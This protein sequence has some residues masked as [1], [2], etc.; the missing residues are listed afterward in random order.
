MFLKTEHIVSDKNIKVK[1][2]ISRKDELF[3]F[4]GEKLV[5]DLIRKDFTPALLLVNS[6]HEKKFEP[7]IQE[8][9]PVWNVSEK[10][11]R[12]ISSLKSPPTIIAVYEELPDNP[13]IYKNKIIFAMDSIQ[14]PGNLGSIFRCAAAFGIRSIALTGECVK[15]TNNKLLRAAQN[16]VFYLSVAKYTSLGDFIT[17][18]VE[19]KFNIYLTSSRHH[20]AQASIDDIELPAVLVL[21]NEGKGVSEKFF[22]N[23]Q[24]ISIGQTDLVESLNAGVSGCILMNQ[25]SEHFRLIKS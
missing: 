7:V 23:Y 4:E 17:E 15:L 1:D 21:G 11:M 9:T 20:G 14:D 19:K 8:G 24:T 13:G 6:E 18:A 16:S 10:V 22:R 3:I 12:K 2:L 5:S 25:V